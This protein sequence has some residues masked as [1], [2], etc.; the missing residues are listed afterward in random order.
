VWSCFGY[1]VAKGSHLDEGKYMSYTNDNLSIEAKLRLKES[2]D[3]KGIKNNIVIDSNNDDFTIVQLEELLAPK[4]D[5]KFL[6]QSKTALALASQKLLD[7]AENLHAA[8]NQY[9]QEFILRG[10]DVAY[11]LL[12]DMHGLAL[13]INSSPDADKILGIMRSFLKE[14][15]DIKLNKSSTAM[16]TLVR[17]VI[18][19]DKLTASRYGKVLEVAYEEGIKTENFIDFVKQR[20][21]ISK[22]T[23]TQA[24][25]IIQDDLK[26]TQAARLDFA[27]Q[28]CHL[29]AMASENDIEYAKELT[30]HRQDKVSKGDSSRFVYFMASYLGGGKYRLISGHDFD[31]SFEDQILTQIAKPL[32]SNLAVIEQSVRQFMRQILKK[33][34]LAK[35]QKDFLQSELKKP[36]VYSEEVNQVI[37]VPAT[38]VVAIPQE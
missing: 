28:I 16:G 6:A 5:E 35:G 14:K 17:Y 11:T 19:A 30:I 36:L 26:R 2:L 13:E 20:G 31:R 27:S 8:H 15:C 21:G 37:D 3:A 38:T 25:K 4:F 10:R 29:L 22:I 1:C 33:D 12:R 7:N 23:A 32:P 34:S 9:E 18:R 24:E